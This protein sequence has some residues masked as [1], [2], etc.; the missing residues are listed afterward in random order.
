MLHEGLRDG[1]EGLAVLTEH[2]PGFRLSRRHDAANF[3]VDQTRRFFGHVLALRDR[4]AEEHFLLVVGIAERPELFAHTPLGH[5]AARE[6]C[7]LLDV[8]RSAGVQVLFAVD[9][10]L[11]DAP[12]KRH[13]EA[14]LAPLLGIAELVALRQTHRYAERA[15]AR[16]DRDLVQGIITG[17]EQVQKSV[18]GFVISR[19]ELL[20]LGHGHG[21]PLGTHHDLVLG[22]LELDLRDHAL[23]APRCEQSGFVDE[24]RE[25]GTR[26]AGRSARN[27]LR[28]H[29]RRERHLAHVHAQDLFAADDIGVR[30]RDLPIEAA[31]T[32]QRRIEHVR[33]VGRGENDNAL[34]RFE[35]VHLDEQLVQRLLALVI[36]AAEAGAAMAT[37][38]VDFIDEDDARGVLLRLIEH[39]THA[40][41]TDADEHLDEV[42]ARD[43]EE[44]HVR[45]ACDSAR[46]ER[47]TG[48]RRTDEQ[49]AARNASAELLELL[50]I[51]KELD[52]LLEIDLGLVDA[53]YV[54]ERDAT[55]PLR[56]QLCLGLTE[57]HGPAAARLHLA[58]EEDPHRNQKQHG[59]P[60]EQHVEDRRDVL[61]LRTG[62]DAHALL[63]QALDEGGI[64]GRKAR[65][66]A[67]LVGV[68]PGQP[69]ALDGHLGDVTG[70]N[71]GQQLGVADLVPAS[72]LRRVL[73]HIEQRD[74]KQADNDPDRE[75]PKMRVHVHPFLVAPDRP[76]QCSS[77]R[78]SL[79]LGKARST[80]VALKIG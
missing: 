20:L 18:A 63:V 65:E 37:H 80:S 46:D 40:A 42:R 38:G 36:A 34:V 13:D 27:G 44:G 78:G 45:F 26:E 19:R 16:N 57:A 31:G 59:E 72:L 56:Q 28:V 61:I 62:R 48:T 12:A 50:R 64:L 1:F 11:G 47:L 22:I 52:D 7:R 14:R 77:P 69:V 68:L 76:R 54:L 25:I 41:R 74:Q 70:V 30:H 4:M 10:L 67:R 5:H 23:R 73:E 79:G 6:A 21:A 66:R 3:L 2:L 17:H 24:V 55:V 60:G 8:A 33:T 29:I 39:V 43:R 75:V 15:P 32:Q 58:H 51:T 71:L 53:R 35:A 49:T 9:D